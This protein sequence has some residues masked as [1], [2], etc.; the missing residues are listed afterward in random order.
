[1]TDSTP[2]DGE[3]TSFGQ[4]TKNWYEKHK[5]KLRV[6]LGVTLAVGLGLVVATNLHG[7]PDGERFDAEDIGEWEPES[8]PEVPDE[9]RRSVLD[10]DRSPFLRRLPPGQRASEAAKERYREL[11]GNDLPPGYTVVRRW[12]FLDDASEDEDPGEAAA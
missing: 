12:M 6:A 3:P 9:P 7:R 4:K 2:E 5:S 1:M 11:T 8:G 10:P